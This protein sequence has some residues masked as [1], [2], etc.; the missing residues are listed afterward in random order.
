MLRKMPMIV[1]GMTFT[2]STSQTSY[3]FIQYIQNKNMA[4][5]AHNSIAM[6]KGL[7]IMNIGVITKNTM[8][9][10][11]GIFELFCEIKQAKIN[12]KDID[13]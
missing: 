8:N 7:S 5:A 4:E 13:K 3:G 12:S 10:V 6:K 2:T 9:V 11:A 1:K